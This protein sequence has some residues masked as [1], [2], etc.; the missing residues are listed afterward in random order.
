[1]AARSEAPPG[2][3]TLAR[4]A[5]TQGRK[6]ELAADPLTDIPERFAGLERL[7]LLSRGGERRAFAL[8]HHWMH[9]GRVVLELEGIG[10]LT[11]A[12]AWVGA[13]VQVPA[14]E[15][16]EAPAGRYFISDLEGCEVFDR[17]RALGAV[18]GV[19]EIAGGAAL[20]HVAAATGEVLIPFAAEYVESVSLAERR[21]SL[22]LPEGL[23]E[24]NQP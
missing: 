16:A 15:R 10:D 24:I 14:S 4:I 8:R 6:G 22:K 9:Q 17:G 2:W 7:W 5:K 20:L 13:E 12:A 11:A 21:L 1:M 3:V 19:E 23:V 18:T